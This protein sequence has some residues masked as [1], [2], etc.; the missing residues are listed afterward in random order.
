MFPNFIYGIVVNIN[1]ISFNYLLIYYQT[2]KDT[3]K[4]KN[5]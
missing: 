3:K 1:Y 2:V 5:K 4:K